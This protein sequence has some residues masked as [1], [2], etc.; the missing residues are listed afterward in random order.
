MEPK[1]QYHLSHQGE[2]GY[3]AQS[4]KEWRL[5]CEYIFIQIERRTS[6]L[7]MA[8]REV[9]LMKPTHQYHLSYQGEYVYDAQS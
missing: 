4:W 1:H 7:I 9:F 8:I 2:C 5:L 3:D 6:I